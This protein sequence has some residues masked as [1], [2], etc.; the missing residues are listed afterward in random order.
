MK[1]I[2]ILFLAITFIILSSC[3]DAEQGK[4][5]NFGNS[6]KVEMYSGG[7]LVRSWTSTGKVS[8]EDGSDGYFFKDAATG[9]LVEIS[10]DVV[11]T[12]ID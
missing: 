9:K 10:G 12:N 1:K 2:I 6:F 7:Q 3:T 8:S 4:Y 5:T 11:I